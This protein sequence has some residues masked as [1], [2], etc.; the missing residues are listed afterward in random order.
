MKTKTRTKK[1]TIKIVKN[2]EIG[3]YIDFVSTNEMLHYFNELC[4]FHN[5][6]DVKCLNY[7]TNTMYF[8]NEESVS[9][10]EEIILEA[11]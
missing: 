8:H 10:M 11:N 4:H 3:H 9:I 2:S 5:A 6:G 1:A 7:G